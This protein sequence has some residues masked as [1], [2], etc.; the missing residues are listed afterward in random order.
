MRR[1]CRWRRRCGLRRGCRRGEFPCGTEKVRIFKQPDNIFA[2]NMCRID[3]PFDVND[4]DLV[5]KAEI[6]GRRQ[7]KIIF[8]FL[9]KNIPGFEN[10]R[11]LQS[12]DNLGV[13]ESR[14]VV[15]E[16]VLRHDDI[17][18]STIFDDAIVIL[19]STVDVHTSTK[20]VYTPN[21]Y[22]FFVLR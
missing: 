14:R 12:S 19:S 5:T 15:G 18:N 9:K 11:L 6:E 13:R 20:V 16:Y 17:L 1:A 7:V 2:V 8:D 3:E 10:I 22:N 21:Y 4:P